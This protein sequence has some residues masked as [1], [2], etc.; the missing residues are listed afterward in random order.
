MQVTPGMSGLLAG[1]TVAVAR[2]V[3]S[4]CRT[5]AAAGH[6]GPFGDAIAAGLAGGMTAGEAHPPLHLPAAPSGTPPLRIRIA[7]ALRAGGTG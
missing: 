1:S 6:P 5:A 4:W 3:V 2:A 7:A